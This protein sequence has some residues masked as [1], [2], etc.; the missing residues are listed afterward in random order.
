MS[1][2]RADRP[3]GGALILAAGFGRRFGADKRTHQ[4][5]NGQTLL[6]ATIERYAEVYASLC[7]VLR[8]GDESLT[9]QIRAL[10][11]NPEIALSADAQLGMGH[12]LA[13]G[14]RTIA[15]DWQWV[16]V[17]L[18]DM[19]FISSATLIELLDVFFAAAAD[20]IVQPVFQGTPGHPVTF[21]KRCFSDLCRLEGDQGARTVLQNDGRLIRHP[22]TDQGVLDDVDTPAAAGRW[23]R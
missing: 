16:S 15:D 5:P 7:V 1:A 19:P 13:A 2:E 3:A 11:G 22:V 12:S 4:L 10:P 21:P 17:A 8:P 9:R 23:Q 18:G 20:S 14:V 6:Q